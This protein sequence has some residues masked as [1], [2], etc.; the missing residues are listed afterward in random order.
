MGKRDIRG[1]YERR[2]AGTFVIPA[3]VKYRRGLSPSRFL[4]FFFCNEKRALAF[5][6][7]T[8]GEGKGDSRRTKVLQGAL[9]FDE[10]GKEPRA[11]PS[12]TPEIGGACN[13]P[14]A[15]LLNTNSVSQSTKE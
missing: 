13:S 14:R 9:A 11:A 15:A 3:I 2:C 8:H 1:K 4:R 5:D 12:P 10:V 6:R 7:R